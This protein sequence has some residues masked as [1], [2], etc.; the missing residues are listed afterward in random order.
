MKYMNDIVRKLVAYLLTSIV[1]L[2]LGLVNLNSQAEITTTHYH[3]DALGS[4]VAATNE[5]GKMIWKENYMSYGSKVENQDLK[6]N[7]RIGYTG[8]VHDPD[9]GLTYMQA[10]YY[11]PV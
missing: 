6:T 7:N 10:R 2:S 8:H 5:L 9:T 4:P 3:T 1:M 11:D